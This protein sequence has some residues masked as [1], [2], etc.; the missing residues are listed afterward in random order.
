MHTQFRP[1]LSEGSVLQTSSC[2]QVGCRHWIRRQTPPGVVAGTVLSRPNLY[3]KVE[4]HVSVAVNLYHV[5]KFR[6]R[7][8]GHS[9]RK[10]LCKFQCQAHATLMQQRELIFFAQIGSQVERIQSVSVFIVFTTYVKSLVLTYFSLYTVYTL[11]YYYYYY[12]Y[13]YAYFFKVA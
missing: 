7:H 11:P 4:Y 6:V 9:L 12:Y 10:R 5:L 8:D 3:S 2:G 1:G 13:Y